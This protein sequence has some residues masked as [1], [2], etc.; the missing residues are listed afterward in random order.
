MDLV[1]DIPDGYNDI[2][3]YL[4]RALSIELK[5]ISNRLEV[6]NKICELSEGVFLYAELLVEDVKNGAVDLGNP[7]SFP[8]G[9]SDFYRSSME[10]KFRSN[11]SFERIRDFLEL[12]VVSE[13]IPEQI[14][15][16]ACKYSKY[17]YLSNLDLLGSWV[18]RQEGEFTTLNFS[19]KSLSDWFTD[20]QRSGVYF[21]D[22]KQGALLLARYCR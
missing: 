19:H 6:L 2:M 20:E 16:N 3:A 10:R 8:R 15:I 21:V 9:L 7:N 1:E 11:E 12:L 14:L 18:N 4:L 13:S 17:I 22:K 5:Q